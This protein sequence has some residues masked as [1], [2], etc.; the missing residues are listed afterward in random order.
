MQDEQ[1]PTGRK[2]KRQAISATGNVINC[3]GV[4]RVHNPE[5]GDQKCPERSREIRPRVSIAPNACSL[6]E[7]QNQQSIEKETACDVQQNVS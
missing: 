4:D 6:A 2:Q 7:Q 1:P 3:R 5:C